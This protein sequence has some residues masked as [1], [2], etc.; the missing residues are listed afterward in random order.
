MWVIG[1]TDYVIC[2]VYLQCEVGVIRCETMLSVRLEDGWGF[3]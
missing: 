3:C 1:D 2:E